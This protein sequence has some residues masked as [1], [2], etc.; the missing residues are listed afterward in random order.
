MCL[1]LTKTGL[2]DDEIVKVSEA[3]PQFW[4]GMQ[5]W[6]RVVIVSSKGHYALSN[7]VFRNLVF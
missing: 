3:K 7:E 2:N 1:A 5:V 6:L 4:Y